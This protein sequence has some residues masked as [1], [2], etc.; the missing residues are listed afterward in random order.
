MLYRDFYESA[1]ITVRNAWCYYYD[2]G[3]AGSTIVDIY[4]ADFH[5]ET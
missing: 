4:L 3:D 2:L 1:S 5:F